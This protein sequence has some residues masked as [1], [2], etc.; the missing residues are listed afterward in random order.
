MTSISGL[1]IPSSSAKRLRNNKLGVVAASDDVVVVN[2]NENLLKK[3]KKKKQVALSGG[4][5]GTVV[6]SAMHADDPHVQSLC[7]IRADC[8]K[9]E[10][11]AEDWN[12]LA[13]HQ[14]YHCGKLNDF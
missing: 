4:N 2:E 1:N 14:V 6:Y 13:E 3:I 5:V 8:W 10:A 7:E 12:K 9:S 11:A